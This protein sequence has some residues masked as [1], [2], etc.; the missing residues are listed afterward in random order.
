MVRGCCC[1]AFS[2]TTSGIRRTG[3]LLGRR[4][5]DNVWQAADAIDGFIGNRVADMPRFGGSPLFDHDP[6]DI[7]AE[8]QLNVRTHPFYL[9]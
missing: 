6:L 8:R 1:S 2:F 4:L 3:R 5:Q 9:R 7:G